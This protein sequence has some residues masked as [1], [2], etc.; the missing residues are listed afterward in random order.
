MKQLIILAVLVVVGYFAYQH[1]FIAPQQ[2]DTAEEDSS[3]DSG[4]FSINQLPPISVNCEG[5]AKNLENAFYGNISG[6]VSFAQRNFA[7]RKLRSCLQNDGFSD[8]QINGTVVEIKERVKGYW[9]QD[10]GG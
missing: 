10:S 9:L 1:F 3:I 5:Q 2:N 7:D 8:P 6:R 4:S